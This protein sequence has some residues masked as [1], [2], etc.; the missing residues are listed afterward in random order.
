[1]AKS[2]KDEARVREVKERL[3]AVRIPQSLLDEL[4]QQLER[5]NKEAPWVQMTRSDAVRWLLTLALRQLKEKH[6]S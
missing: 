2:K 1:M 4:D 3:L 6:E 5:M